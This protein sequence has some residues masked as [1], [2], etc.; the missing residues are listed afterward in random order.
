MSALVLRVK[1]LSDAA[2]LPVR[3]SEHAAGYD[4][5]RC[6]TTATASTTTALWAHGRSRTAPS[7]HSFPRGARLSSRQTLP[8]P[9]RS[10]T[11]GVSVRA[12]S[13][14]PSLFSFRWLT[15]SLGPGC[16]APRS[17]L[18]WKHFVDVGAG[19]IDSDYRGNVG[20]VL[21]NFSETDFKIEIGDRIA[22]LIIE[23]IATPAVEEEEVRC[24]GGGQTWCGLTLACA[25]RSSTKPC[26]DS[27]GMDPRAA[28]EEGARKA[29]GGEVL[30]TRFTQA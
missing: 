8:W 14:P 17:S 18:A 12:A 9:F 21:Y 10:A 6:V 25:R 26:E 28:V 11:T 7:R 16:A 30:R 20:V 3:A 23:K 24:P 29:S 13:L 22:Q 5:F 15:D 1:R 27:V 19:V 2:K 4:L